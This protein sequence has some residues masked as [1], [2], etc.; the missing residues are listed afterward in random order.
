MRTYLRHIFTLLL[1]GI[2]SLSCQAANGNT[3]QARELFN[4]V[5]NSAFGP[6]GSTLSYK[7]NIIGL[8]KTQGTIVYKGKKRRFADERLM[9]WEDGITA[10]MVDKKAHEVKIYRPDDDRKDKWLSKFKYDVNNFDISYTAKGDFYFITAKVK[11]SSF[12]GIRWV[13]AKVRKSD[14]VP[15]SL[16]IKLAFIRTTVL[17]TNFRSG[18]ISDNEF[19]FP[20]NQFKGYKFIDYRND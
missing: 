11:N 6:Q 18:N 9:G 10:Y 1:L 8:Y 13:M 12:F 20:R 14:L 5:Y 15:V 17:I 3:H 16:S 19:I 2:S 7:V 4:K